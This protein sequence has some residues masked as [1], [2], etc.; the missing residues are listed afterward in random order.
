[1]PPFGVGTGQA[2][3]T[4]DL[5]PHGNAEGTLSFLALPLNPLR[6]ASRAPEGPVVRAHHLAADRLAAGHAAPATAGE[7][8]GPRL[9][10][11]LALLGPAD[12]PPGLPPVDNGS[13]PPTCAR[14]GR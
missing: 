4:F 3:F 11:R 12:E 5:K 6:P 8:H 1:M 10:G 2:S 7:V 14:T 13:R 9:P